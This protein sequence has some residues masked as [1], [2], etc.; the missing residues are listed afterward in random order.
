ME[1]SRYKEPNLAHKMMVAADEFIS[2][3][4]NQVWAL[5]NVANQE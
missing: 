4:V 3:H 2:D 1:I 5:L